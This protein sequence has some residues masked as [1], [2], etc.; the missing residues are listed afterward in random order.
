MRLVLRK[1][2]S[3]LATTIFPLGLL[4]SCG[5]VVYDWCKPWPIATTALESYGKHTRICVGISWESKTTVLDGQS[6]V[7]SQRQRA[8]LIVKAPITW[9]LMVMISE[10]QDAK[11]TVDETMSGLVLCL[12]FLTALL[13][14][15]WYFWL[16]RQSLATSPAT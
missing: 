2:I 6:T 16:R 3:R 7:S 9:P 15:T 4:V 14:G 12:L 11:V 1:I 5:I 8:F 13:W 10:D